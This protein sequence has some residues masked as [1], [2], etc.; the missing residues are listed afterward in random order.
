M[1]KN[2]FYVIMCIYCT[3]TSCQSS[4][5][6]VTDAVNQVCSSCPIEISKLSTISKVEFVNNEIIFY[7]IYIESEE[8]FQNYTYQ[9]LKRIES[10]PKFVKGVMHDIFRQPIVKD[11]FKDISLNVAE[12]IDLRLKA[13]VKGNTSDLEIVCK[14]SWRDVLQKY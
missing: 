5:Q 8:S 10:N 4:E 7:T 2:L 9:D 12:E 11:A 13:I 6:K 3:C 14:M 1:K